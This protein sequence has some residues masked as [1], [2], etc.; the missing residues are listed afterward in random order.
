MNHFADPGYQLSNSHHVSDLNPSLDS[1][2]SWWIKIK[3]AI[4][5]CVYYF[6]PF[7][8]QQEAS[9]LQYGYVEDLI[10][11]KAYGITTEIK[12]LQPTLLTIAEED[13]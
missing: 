7:T 9:K 6:G 2:T 4:P 3:T 5:S 8:N 1:S 13:S 11:E 10:E 12:Q